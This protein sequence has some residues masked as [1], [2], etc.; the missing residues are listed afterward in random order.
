MLPGS[1]HGDRKVCRRSTFRLRGQRQR[2]GSGFSWAKS[3]ALEPSEETCPQGKTCG[4]SL[5]GLELSSLAPRHTQTSLALWGA[6]MGN[7]MNIT[8][9]FFLSRK[10]LV[11]LYKHHPTERETGN[12]AS[13]AIFF[14]HRSKAELVSSVSFLT[15]FLWGQTAHMAISPEQN[16]GSSWQGFGAIRGQE[17]SCSSGCY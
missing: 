1:K 6:G 10:I 15:A 3:M 11:H 9:D 2:L 13:L 8:C 7:I 5:Q 4:G 16:G 12:V 14:L 17:N